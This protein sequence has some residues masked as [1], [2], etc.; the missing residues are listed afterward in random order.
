M[1]KLKYELITEKN[2][3]LAVKVQNEIFPEE[4]GKKNFI[5]AINKDPY[6]KEL[7]YYLVFDNETPIG[8]SG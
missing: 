7:T 1:I 2:L 6:R 5:D 4:N 3:D 8:V